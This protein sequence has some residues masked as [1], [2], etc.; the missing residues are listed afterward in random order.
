LK[1]LILCPI[2]L[3]FKEAFKAFNIHTKSPFSLYKSRYLQTKEKEILLYSTNGMQLLQQ[4]TEK[5]IDVFQPNIIIDSGSAALLNDKFNIG[6]IFSVSK[7]RTKEKMISTKILSH[8]FQEASVFV[9]EN[10]ILQDDKKRQEIFQNYQC[11]LFTWESYALYK[12]ACEYNIEFYSFRTSSDKG[13]KKALKTFKKNNSDILSHF[14]KQL[15][16]LLIA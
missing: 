10:H 6:D 12:I 2:A 13:D 5:A 16:T 8:S 11:D 1:I 9:Q 7:I 15:F 3:E 14:Y 4:E